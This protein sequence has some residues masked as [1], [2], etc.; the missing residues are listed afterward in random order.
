ME[1]PPHPHG[2]SPQSWPPWAGPPP[3]LDVTLGQPGP[4]PTPLPWEPCSQLGKGANSLAFKPLLCFSAAKRPVSPYSGYNG[5]LLTSVYQPT[6]MALM[7]KG[8][9]S[10]PESPN[11]AGSHLAQSLWSGGGLCGQCGAWCRWQGGGRRPHLGYRPRG[12]QGPSSLCALFLELR[13][14]LSSV[15]LWGVPAC[16]V[17]LGC[18]TLTGT[19]CYGDCCLSSLRQWELPAPCR[20]LGRDRGGPQPAELGVILRV[21]GGSKGTEEEVAG[22]GGC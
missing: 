8:P 4:L 22:L 7:H 5:Q 16:P 6:E 2:F 13:C 1:G 18:H 14:P 19:A 9:V 3:G 10:G 20:S 12:T 15:T 21:G 17:P 11:P